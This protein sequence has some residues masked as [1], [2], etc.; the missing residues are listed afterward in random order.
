MT[1]DFG[2]GAMSERVR[3]AARRSA[4]DESRH[5]RQNKGHRGR[6][7]GGS[8]G[9][10]GGEAGNAPATDSEEEKSV[11]DRGGFRAAAG[12]HQRHGEDRHEA[13][14]EERSEEHTSE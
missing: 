8:H 14:D 12:V 13:H 6:P 11:R 4:S 5:G 1:I 10:Q 9:S 7:Q 2:M 3:E